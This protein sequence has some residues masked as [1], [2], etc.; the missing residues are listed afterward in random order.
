MDALKSNIRSFVEP[1]LPDK[2]GLPETSSIV[3][4][5]GNSPANIASAASSGK[6]DQNQL[7]SD[8]NTKQPSPADVEGAV[9]NANHFLEQISRELRFERSETDGK[10]VVQVKDQK[11]GEVIRQFPS[12]EML[13]ISKDLEKMTGLLFKDSA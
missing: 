2:R 1:V 12:E 4:L 6:L 8:D 9:K 5:N 10:M 7:A 11:T 13:K 3:S